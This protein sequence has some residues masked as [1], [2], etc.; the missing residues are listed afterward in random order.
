M[1]VVGGARRGEAAG[2]AVAGLACIAYRVVLN[3]YCELK[4]YILFLQHCTCMSIQEDH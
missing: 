2:R 4:R 1:V 3:N